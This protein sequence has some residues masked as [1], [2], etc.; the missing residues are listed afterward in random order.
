MLG[1]Q[2]IQRLRK[3]AGLQ[4]ANAAINVQRQLALIGTTSPLNVKC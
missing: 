1:N 3:K 2:G 4:Q